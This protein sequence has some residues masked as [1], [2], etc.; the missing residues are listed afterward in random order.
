MGDFESIVWTIAGN[1]KSAFGEDAVWIDDVVSAALDDAITYGTTYNSASGN[2]SIQEYTVN[3]DNLT[4]LIFAKMEESGVETT[5]GLLKGLT[6]EQQKVYNEARTIGLSVLEAYD[7]ALGIHSPSIEMEK[8][9]EYTL[10]GLVNGL[11]NVSL[12]DVAIDSIVKQFDILP[13]IKNLWSRVTDWWKNLS[14]P[15]INL[16]GN[17]GAKIAGVFNVGQYA[18]G[19]FPGTGQ[20]FIAREAGPELVGR[21]GNKN[22]VANNDQITAGIASAVYSAMMAAQED[23]HGNNGNARIVVQIGD[24]VVGEA[25]VNYINGQ[26]VQTGTSP[27][28]S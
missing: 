10:Q 25:A 4:N 2:Y 20:M 28:Y 23:G 21:I 12:L 22:A 15:D 27:I 3:T 8:R 1:L 16:F 11:S 6:E 18:A 7:K 13:S 17:F 24:R 14:L 26:I 19:G 5:S 9:G